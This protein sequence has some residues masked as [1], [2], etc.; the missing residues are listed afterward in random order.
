LDKRL[1]KIT[2]LHLVDFIE[3]YITGWLTIRWQSWALPS[4]NTAHRGLYE[5]IISEC[6]RQLPK[7]RSF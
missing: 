1:Q 5:T 7:I 4:K 3:R 6:Y 2:K